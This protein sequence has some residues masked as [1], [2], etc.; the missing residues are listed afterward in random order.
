M[1]P[2][3]FANEEAAKLRRPE[4]LSETLAWSRCRNSGRLWGETCPEV[5]TKKSWRVQ[6]GAINGKDDRELLVVK[7]KVF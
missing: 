5:M 3:E 4:S 7:N 6:L 1:S 2:A